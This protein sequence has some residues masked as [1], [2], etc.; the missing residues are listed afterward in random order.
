MEYEILIEEELED[1][2][3]AVALYIIKKWI[4]QGGMAVQEKDL[5]IGYKISYYYQ[6]MIKNVTD[7][8][9]SSTERT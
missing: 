2:E 3:A 6:A 8:A 4:P 9:Q 7:K 1:L 5:E